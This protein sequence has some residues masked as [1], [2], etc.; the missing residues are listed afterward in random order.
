ML[1]SKL[2]GKGKLVN[3]KLVDGDDK[4]IASTG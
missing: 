1:H 2:A 3:K 4:G